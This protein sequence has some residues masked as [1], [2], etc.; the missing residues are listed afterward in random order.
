MAWIGA[1]KQGVNSN[2]VWAKAQAV[3]TNLFYLTL[4]SP[5]LVRLVPRLQSLPLLLKNIVGEEKIAEL[6][7][8]SI[9]RLKVI[10]IYN[11][12]TTFWTSAVISSPPNTTT[13]FDITIS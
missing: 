7:E 4:T 9:P 10:T 5:V 6:N 8:C 11:Y 3:P 2:V 12:F 1:E 13:P